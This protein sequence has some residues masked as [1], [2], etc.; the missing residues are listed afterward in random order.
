M[1]NNAVVEVEDLRVTRGRTRAVDGV[2]FTTRPGEV[3]GLLGPSGCGKTTLMRSVVGV[4]V[5]A[6]GRVKVLGRP[7]GH[8]SLRNRV[9]NTPTDFVGGNYERAYRL[10]SY[11]GR[12]G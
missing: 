10:P 5:V 11:G 1:V 7:A 9:G 12:L 4:Q 8:R 2:G 6:G 3:T